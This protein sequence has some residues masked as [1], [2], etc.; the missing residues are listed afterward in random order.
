MIDSCGTVH[1][2]SV[3]EINAS[4]MDS[5]FR[6][7]GKTSRCFVRFIV[8][9][10]PA[11]IPKRSMYVFMYIVIA[12]LRGDRYGTDERT[13]THVIK[14]IPI[15]GQCSHTS[16]FDKNVYSYPKYRYTNMTFKI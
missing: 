9:S 5:V 6:L 10:T 3:Q 13:N 7:Q 14:Q 12:F 2:L 1:W 4:G 11:F 15:M 16:L 8:C